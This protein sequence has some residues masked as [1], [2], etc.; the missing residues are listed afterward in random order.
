MVFQAFSARWRRAHRLRTAPWRVNLES[1]MASASSGVSFCSLACIVAADRSIQTP[2][3]CCGRQ[4]RNAPADGRRS[5]GTDCTPAPDTRNAALAAQSGTGWP[6]S[7]FTNALN[8]KPNSHNLSA[9]YFSAQRPGFRQAQRR[10][11]FQVPRQAG[12]HHVRPV[13]HQGI[14]RR[15]QGLHA[16][17]SCCIRFS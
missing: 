11:G 1:I 16:V 8:S 12:H 9:R 4:Q 7:A 10:P 17:L 6:P 15:L 13:A 2:T 14:H 5:A 3:S